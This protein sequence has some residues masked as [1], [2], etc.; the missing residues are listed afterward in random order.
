[1]DTK[2]VI[3][4]I[5]S[6]FLIA[7]IYSSNA[8]YYVSAKQVT[9]CTSSVR[10]GSMSTTT[11]CTL[12]FDDNTGLLVGSSC[13][14]TSCDVHPDGLC[15]VWKGDQNKVK[16]NINPEDLGALVGNNPKLK[17]PNADILKDNVTLQENNDDGKVPKAPKVPEDLGGLNDDGG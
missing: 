5:I 9:G 12:T 10:V 1:M 11:C 14:T 8:T 3:F 13:T 17:G 2:Y 7:A 4:V 16:G 15:Y 6:T